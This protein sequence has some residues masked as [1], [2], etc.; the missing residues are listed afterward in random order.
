MA[1]ELEGKRKLAALVLMLDRSSAA[2]LLQGI[3]EARIP[4]IGR[5]MLDLATRPLPETEQIRI[6]TEFRRDLENERQRNDPAARLRA[7]LETSLGPERM[8]GVLR[9]IEETPDP[10]SELEGLDELEPAA[11]AGALEQ[12]QPQVAAIFLLSIDS[13]RAAE[14]LARLPD[15]LRTELMLRMATRPPAAPAVV[16]KV[17]KSL[18]ERAKPKAVGGDPRRL[19]RLAEILNRIPGGEGQKTLSNLA[20]RDAALA[21]QLKELRFVF[22]DLLRLEKKTLQKALSAVDMGILGR[23][24]HAAAPE[25]KE[26]ILKN[27]SQR[28]RE[29]I[30]EEMQ[31]GPPLTPKESYAAQ[32]EIVKTLLAQADSGQ[33]DLT[34]QEPAKGQ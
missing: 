7:I 22:D 20:L 31:S 1:M 13:L 24:L 18:R 30:E 15:E 26:R 9:R 4:E 23:A 14:I 27:V 8:A 21:E 19:K 28:V 17:V 2:R 10:A 34:A 12:E 11:L 16:A 25:I 3:P 32:R 6:L 5:E 33:L 29:R